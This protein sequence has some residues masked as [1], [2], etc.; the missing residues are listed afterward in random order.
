MKLNKL[1][2]LKGLREVTAAFML[3]AT[4]FAPAGFTRGL[5]ASPE[6][7]LDMTLAYSEAADKRSLSGTRLTSKLSFASLDVLLQTVDFH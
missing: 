4:V 6:D 5:A 1:H 2:H 7:T 3:F